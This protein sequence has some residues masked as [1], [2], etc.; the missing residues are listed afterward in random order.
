MHIWIADPGRRDSRGV[1]S[2]RSR[3]KD[4]PAALLNNFCARLRQGGGFEDL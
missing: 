4:F 2:G 3:A 1:H